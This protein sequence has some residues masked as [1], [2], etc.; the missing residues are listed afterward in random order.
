VQIDL[1]YSSIGRDTNSKVWFLRLKPSDLEVYVL[2]SKLKLEVQ[3]TGLFGLL[4]L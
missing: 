2:P 1:S 3:G 4:S